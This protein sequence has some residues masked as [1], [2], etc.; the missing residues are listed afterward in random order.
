MPGGYG[1]HQ[2]FGPSYRRLVADTVTNV[3]AALPTPFMQ[4]HAGEAMAMQGWWGGK[5]NGKGK[6]RGNQGGGE[7]K[8]AR[9]LDQRP[10][11]QCMACGEPNNFPRRD[12][13]FRCRVPRGSKAATASK[14]KGKGKGKGE[15][16]GKGLA[17]PPPQLLRPSWDR[18]QG[19]AIGAIGADGQR[20]IFKFIANVARERAKGDPTKTKGERGDA[21]GMDL[22]GFRVVARA[23]GVWPRVGGTDV[24]GGRS[25]G[26]ITGK[27]GPKGGK[28]EDA[29]IAE[30]DKG[31]GP[32]PQDRAFGGKGGKEGP[33]PKRPPWADLNDDDGDDGV[34]GDEL[35]D[36]DLDHDDGGSEKMDDEDMGETNE[37]EDVDGYWDEDGPPEQEEADGHEEMEQEPEVEVLRQRWQNKKDVFEAVA[38]KYTK[39]QPQ[40]EDARA[41]R[42][43][44]YKAWQAASSAQAAPKLATLYQRKQRT[45]D[46]A[47]RKLERTMHEADEELRRHEE[48]MDRLQEQI[49]QD[50]LRIDDAA[51]GVREVA[52]QVAASEGADEGAEEDSPTIDRGALDQAAGARKELES[53]Q[54]QLQE[55]HDKLE[56][57]GNYTACEQV[58]LLY[59]SL[60]GAA[61]NIEGV[62]QHLVRPR[63]RRQQRRAEHYSMDQGTADASM[64][65]EGDRTATGGGERATANNKATPKGNSGT[66]RWESKP[67]TRGNNDGTARQDKAPE[68]ATG[69][70]DDRQ[71]GR[72]GPTPTPGTTNGNAAGGGTGSATT[73]LRF[74]GADTEDREKDLLRSEALQALEQARAKFQGA[75]RSQDTDNATLLYAHQLVLAK[76]GAPTTLEEREAYERWRGALGANLEQVAAER[77]ADGDSCW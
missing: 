1:G 37:Y 14:G 23:A 76:I 8:G 69:C 50:Q 18:G 51:A 68:Q 24:G 46:R 13:C 26:R 66:N 28:M 45:L 47:K 32:Q 21:D 42:D 17:D 58:N 10:C 35:W 57:Q 71:S 53:A 59:G 56:E 64:E 63:P 43:R 20:P 19:G 60:A 6:G 11:W 65:K 55:L 4:N 61:G 75:E 15:T 25:E 22:E 38:C 52:R 40:L 9:L 16:V 12:S 73:V 31:K 29:H 48:R 2:S 33:V 27:E 7:G 77:R 36:D 70:D 62:E 30:A 49:R 44:A 54:A 3:L 74:G 72:G 34:H 39:G 5:A 41:E 67:R